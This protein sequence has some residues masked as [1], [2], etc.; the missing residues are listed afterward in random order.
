M[1]QARRRAI[2]QRAN[3]ESAEQAPQDSHISSLRARLLALPYVH[4]DENG[5][6]RNATPL[7]K[8]DG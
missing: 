7:G 5:V 4:E 1:S 2:A 3:A 8:V 6:I